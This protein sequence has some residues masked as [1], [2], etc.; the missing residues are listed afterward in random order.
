MTYS[1]RHHAGVVRTI[2]LEFQRHHR[3]P[4]TSY[5]NIILAVRLNLA[6]KIAL[7][8]LASRQDVPNGSGF[9]VLS[10]LEYEIEAAT[11][12][13][14]YSFFFFLVPLKESHFIQQGV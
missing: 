3:L 6:E 1:H 11:S 5:N 13:A 9:A 8:V 4:W 7:T 14:V 12:S 10:A 2:W